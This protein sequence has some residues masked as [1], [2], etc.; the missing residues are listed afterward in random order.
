MADLDLSPGCSPGAAGLRSAGVRVQ[1]WGLLPHGD[2]TGLGIDRAAG[3]RA[4]GSL[5]GG[6]PSSV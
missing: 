2:P 1:L 4:A 6:D 3:G 5:P